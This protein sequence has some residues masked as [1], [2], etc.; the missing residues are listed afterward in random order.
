MKKL[1]L[2]SITLFSLQAFA[3]ETDP[4]ITDRPTQSASASVMSKGKLLVE[5]GFVSENTTNS[6]TN[7]T[8][9]NL[10]LRYGVIEGVEIRL[11][12]NY[13]GR[14]NDITDFSVNGF[15]PLT[16]G[17]KVHLLE[18]SGALPQMSIIGQVTLANGKSAFKLSQVI[19]E[20]RLNFTNTLSDEFSLGYN[21]GMSLPQA[22]PTVVYTVVLG[23]TFAEKWTLFAEPYGSFANSNVHQFNTGLIYL[24]SN[25]VQFD[26]SA[27]WGLSNTAPDSF[28]GFGAAIG[29]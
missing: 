10:L 18:E 11:T 28:I 27:G 14:R 4:I 17:T 24:C 16:I 12:Q 3:Q 25:N 22:D 9:G 21:I 20:V 29:F 7:I 13:L 19:P 2:F 6:I 26:I 23:Y 1:I 5:A 15:S 8:F